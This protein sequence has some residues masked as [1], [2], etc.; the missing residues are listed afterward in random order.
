MSD[1]LQLMLSVD[2]LQSN[3]FLVNFSLTQD[4]K[5][6]ITNVIILTKRSFIETQILVLNLGDME[7]ASQLHRKPTTRLRHGIDDDND[8]DDIAIKVFLKDFFIEQIIFF[9]F[10]FNGHAWC[11][12]WILLKITKLLNYYHLY[13]LLNLKIAF[14]FSITVT[15]VTLWFGHPSRRDRC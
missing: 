13:I 7:E 10:F 6:T 1:W 12:W 2:V 5:E 8:G 9:A 4:I 3:S 15:T 14:F 11:K